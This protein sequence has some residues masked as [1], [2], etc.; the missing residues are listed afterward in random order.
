MHSPENRLARLLAVVIIVSTALLIAGVAWQRADRSRRPHVEPDRRLY[1]IRGIDISSHNGP[2][3]FGAAAAD[4]IAF[5]YLKASEGLSF[6]DSSFCRNHAAARAAGMAVGAYH[7]FR[8]DCDGRRQAI[9]MLAAVDTCRLDLP[10]AIDVE[11]WGNAAGCTTETVVMRLHAMVDYLRAQGRRVVV[12]TNK[13]GFWRFV[14][15]NFEDGDSV[16]VWICSFTSPPLPGD[17]W[18]FWQHS[19]QGRVSGI[20]GPVDLNTFRGD[21]A[22]WRRLTAPEQ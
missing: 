15:R 18:T 16:G 3:D 4:G 7:F 2:V 22:A 13:N 20:R 6:R 12:Y 10:L 1:P 8:F 5:V 17:V 9:N 11:E 21:S 19:H 14:H